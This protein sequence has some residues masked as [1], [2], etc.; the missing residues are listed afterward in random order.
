MLLIESELTSWLPFDDS[1]EERRFLLVRPWVLQ[2][3]VRWLLRFLNLRSVRDHEIL[4]WSRRRGRLRTAFGLLSRRHLEASIARVVLIEVVNAIS[5]TVSASG[6]SPRGT[7][8]LHQ[9]RQLQRRRALWTGTKNAKM[10]DPNSKDPGE[11]FAI[12]DL[13]GPSRFLNDALRNP[14]LLFSKLKLDG[15]SPLLH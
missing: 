7:L 1:L 13:W 3:V 12:P 9:T 5:G 10:D 15:S 6:G 14:S 8:E 2:D 4:V 11:A